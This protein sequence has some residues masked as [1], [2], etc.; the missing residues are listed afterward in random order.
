[1]VAGSAKYMQIR[2]S[3]SSRSDIARA[4][5]VPGLTLLMIAVGIAYAWLL[6]SEPLDGDSQHYFDI[7][8]GHIA[9]VHKPFSMRLLHPVVAGLL[10]RTTGVE[11]ETA[12]FLTNLVSL[13]VLTWVGL[14]LILGKIRSLGLA[15]AIVLG[16]TI[17]F[18]FREIYMPDCL[19]AAIA[20]VFF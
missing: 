17:L 15:A 5:W 6:R 18:R 7:A 11:V 10:S 4:W 9:E 20:A 16:P 14:T 1:M 3:D 19:H 2:T 8:S 12:F 13:A